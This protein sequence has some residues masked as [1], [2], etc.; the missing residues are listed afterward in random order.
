MTSCDKKK[1]NELYQKYKDK[2]PPANTEWTEEQQEEL[3]RL[4]S[5]HISSL[6]ETAIFGEAIKGIDKTLETKLLSH[7]PDRRM[8]V[9]SK[10]FKHLPSSELRYL[11]NRISECFDDNCNGAGDDQ[12][13]QS[14]NANS[15]LPTLEMTVH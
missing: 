7:P 6:Q 12:V 8:E 4:Q 10:V 9:L 15:I 11:R 2:E 5:G 3:E 14:P 13:R 1:L